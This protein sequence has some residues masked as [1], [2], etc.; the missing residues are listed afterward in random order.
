M[1]V[2]GLDAADLPDGYTPLEA[3]TIVKCLDDE[4]RVTVVQRA[5]DGVHV[6][7]SIGWLTMALDAE[8]DRARACFVADEEDD[9]EG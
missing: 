2:Y 7:D 1:S 9:D 8:R 5:T 4:G 3:F 6:W